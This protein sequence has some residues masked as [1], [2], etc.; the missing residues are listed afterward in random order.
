MQSSEE[1]K[2]LLK[3]LNARATQAKMDLHDL[4]E[5]LPTNWQ[6]ILE[7]AQTAYDAHAALAQA[8]NKEAGGA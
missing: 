1:Q 6:R 5:E 8:R 4:S 2:A 3:R 7:V